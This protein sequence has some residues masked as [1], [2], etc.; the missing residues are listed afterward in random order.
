MLRLDAHRNRFN[1]DF[2]LRISPNAFCTVRLG[3]GDDF[4]QSK[5][6]NKIVQSS[7]GLP[8]TFTDKK[9]TPWGGLRVL[10][11]LLRKIGW[12]EALEQAPL[13]EP[14]S[15]RGLNPV[16]M[17]KGFLVTIWTGGGRFAH[18]ALVRFDTALRSIFGLS[19]VASVSTFTRF[20]RR[21]GQKEV[22]YVFSHLSRWL[23]NR[24][25]GGSWTVDLDS[26]VLTRYGQQEGSR[27]GYNPW[28]R[29]KRSQHPLMAFAAECR[30]V[31]TAWL[32]PGD[33]TANTNVEN[34]FREVLAVFGDRH[35]IGLLRA[36]SGFC[37]GSFLDLVES[38]NVSYIVVARVMRMIKRK[39]SGLQDWVELDGRTAVAEFMYQAEGWSKARRVVVVRH[40]TEDQRAGLTLLEV[41]GYTYAVYVTNLTL[42]PMQVRALYQ[43]RADSENRIKEL[44]YDF[45]ISGFVSQKFWATETAFRLACWAYNLMALFRQALLGIASKHTLSTL[46]T[47]CFAIGAGLGKSGRRAVLRLGLEEPRRR[48][49]T[50]LFAQ[51]EQLTTTFSLGAKHS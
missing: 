15:N 24:T 44:L 10:E 6:M 2:S 3:L 30:M 33:S 47:Q 13:P 35:Q 28:R 18:T 14:G 21:F 36:D 11:E 48:W 45:A 17:V 43:G 38:K 5:R 16:V 37:I 39:L 27:R 31:V 9:F 8:W 12:E 25:A 1:P 42:P 22:E 4:L 41:P 46:R 26:T 40:R 34:F 19:Q 7:G 50:G 20:F 32:R 49:F 23:W 51:A 29:G